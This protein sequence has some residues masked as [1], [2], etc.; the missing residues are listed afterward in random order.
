M[1][2][3]DKLTLIAPSNQISNIGVGELSL[4]TIETNE[5]M[6]TPTSLLP[7]D[8]QFAGPVLFNEKVISQN[9]AILAKKMIRV[10]WTHRFLP[11]LKL[12]F[13]NAFGF[14]TGRGKLSLRI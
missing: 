1:L 6:E 12:I 11:I 13:Q 9:D 8:F 4:N 5:F 2:K 14:K 3:L 10:N 7:R